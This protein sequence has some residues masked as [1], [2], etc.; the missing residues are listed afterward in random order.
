MGAGVVAGDNWQDSPPH[1]FL[2]VPLTSISETKAHFNCF[3]KKLET[4]YQNKQWAFTDRGDPGTFM[5]PTY[6]LTCRLNVCE[7]ISPS[8]Q[9]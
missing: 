4:Q 7:R 9:L 2:V 3:K 8:Q 5:T 1:Q 6:V